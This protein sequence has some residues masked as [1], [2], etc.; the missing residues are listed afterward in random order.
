[1]R[2]REVAFFAA[3]V[4][5]L[6]C[7]L[8]DVI[9]KRRV[10]VKR[11]ESE[12]F[13]LVLH[14][15][16]K[17]YVMNEN[18]VHVLKGVD[19][20][21]R[22][23]EF[24]AV[25]GP[26]GCGKTTLLNIIGGLD[27]YTSGD[28]LVD[29]ISTENYG[30]R[31]WDVYRNHR[32]GFVFQSYNL[33]PHLSVQR[34][35]E[36]SMTLA[37]VPSA[38]RKA[39][40]IA[41]LERVGLASEAKKK[42]NQLSGGQ[43]QRVAIARAIVNN[44]DIILADEPTGALDSESGVQVMEL[45]KEISKEK[46][47]I[48]VTHNETLANEYSTRIINLKD[49]VVTSDS[50]PYSREEC[51]A[52]GDGEAVLYD[53]EEKEIADGQAENAENVLDFDGSGYTEDTEAVSKVKAAPKNKIAAFFA[54]MNEKGR[55]RREIRKRVRAD[56][57]ARGK[58]AMSYGT[59]IS[60]SFTN[61]LS[62]KGRTAL[63]AFAG[64]IGIIGIV[65]V[66]ALSSGAGIYIQSMEEDALSQYPIQ[67]ERTNTDLQSII[68]ILMEQN[69]ERPDWPD[70][71]EIV[72]NEV[73][74]HLLANLSAALNDTN[75]LKAFK[76]YIEEN[77]DENIGYVKYDYGTTFDVFCNYV[78]DDEKYMKVNPFIEGIADAIPPSLSGFLDKIEQFGALLSV[79]DE[80][81][82]NEDLVKSQY[83]LLGDSKWP[84]SYDEVLIVVDE[85]NSLDDFTLFALGLK[86]PDE[87]M[88]AIMN[89]GEFA[90]ETYQ[91]EELIGLEYRITTG[92]DYYQQDENGKWYKITERN[93][94]REISF[95]EGTNSEGEPNSVT[96]KVVGVIR[97]KKGTQVTSIN[98]N[99]AYTHALTE[100]LSDRAYNS[101]AAKAQRAAGN[102]DI[103][104]GDE[105]TDDEYDARML[106]FGIA[107]M[108]NPMSVRIYA[109]SFNDK[110]KIEKFI[111]DYN[112]ATYNDIKYTDN[113]EM[114]MGY[115]DS[116]TG[117]VTGVLIGF[118]AISLVVSSIMIAIIIYTSV[119]ERRKEI[120]VL[121]SMGARKTDISNVF[122]AESGMI[123]L[124]AG[125]IGVVIALILFMPLNIILESYLSVANLVHIEWWHAVMMI[126]ISVVLSII[127]GFIPS[128]IAA[129]KDPVKCL[130]ED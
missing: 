94:Q 111:A 103:L 29:G 22:K 105:L 9:V 53:K 66:L 60:L 56:R 119:L 21:F 39:R 36:M 125:I 102:V 68:N 3:T 112:S 85:K 51:A 99:I 32:I 37:G 52:D 6:M 33:I 26:S 64:S 7:R 28:I 49:G 13:M 18:T 74:G 14:N 81:I 47:V 118:A 130:R 30:D 86:S 87:L 108:T 20:C 48:M 2:Q 113:L 35:V 122:I 120:G 89:G 58:S 80:M 98:G 16:V 106:E 82:E 54:D 43:M 128:R 4:V 55:K 109:N 38:E 69:T 115:V 57:K 72:V 24:V 65:L 84:T 104:D 1:M 129:K 71:E 44:P 45:L 15:I 59:A 110:E 117:T 88:D 67:I 100:Y 62:K 25:L 17:D 5:C 42:P 73:I 19:V 91:P 41:A 93:D 76:S 8:C 123:G 96:V 77:F 70:N 46:L 10:A 114:I 95:V 50:A 97:P 12:V 11:V 23:C 127:A 101:P 78:G 61:L 27:R 83:E 75:D 31:D 116:L 107:D 90:S 121:R 40:A 34:N 126:A 92:T 63:T 79:W 124:I